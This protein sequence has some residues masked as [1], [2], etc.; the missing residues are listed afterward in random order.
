[1]MT[2]SGQNQ[3]H[4]TLV[5]AHHYCSS[6]RVKIDK[7]NLVNSHGFKVLINSICVD[8]FRPKVVTSCGK[9]HPEGTF[10]FG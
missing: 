9:K 1:M 6:A 3:P 10:I 2:R 8:V 4:R 5:K 7:K